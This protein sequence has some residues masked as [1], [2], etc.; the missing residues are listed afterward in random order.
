MTMTMNKKKKPAA[1]PKK[2]ISVHYTEQYIINPPHP[3]TINVIGCG[4]TGSQVLNSLA[5]MNSALKALGH[6][7]LYVR[8]VDPDKVTEANMGRQLFSMA[9]V[10]TYKC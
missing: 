8:A 6:T 7:G 9:D 1:L 4:G 3:I 2:K 5:R 10:G